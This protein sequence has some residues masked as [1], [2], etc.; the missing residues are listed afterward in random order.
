MKN[1]SN[2]LVRSL[3]LLSLLALIGFNIWTRR[4]VSQVSNVQARVIPP[5]GVIDNDTGGKVPGDPANAEEDFMKIYAAIQTY[6]DQHDGKYP[7]TGQ[8]LE[9]YLNA[10]SN[11]NFHT[12]EEAKSAS[13]IA[14]KEAYGILLNPD[15][16][17]SD[18]PATR[19]IPDQSSVYD[20]YTQRPDGTSLGNPPSGKKDV[21]AMTSLY[22][23]QNVRQLPGQKSKS[24][25]VGFYVVLWNNGTIQ[26]IAYDQVLYVPKG[27]GDFTTAFPG[28]AGVPAN[29]LTYDE[30]YRVAGWKKGPRGEVGGKGQSYN[31]KPVR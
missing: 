9:S 18:N 4:A 13:E 28:Q 3:A 19:K 14:I 22:V 27:S 11:R 1:L 2:R 31:G 30:F 26:K 29:A 23:H 8:I 20:I 21:L 5:E 12:S 7:N 16:K 25:P 6:R 15:A 10:K 24:N 17:Y